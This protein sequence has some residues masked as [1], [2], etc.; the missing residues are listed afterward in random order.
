MVI[1]GHNHCKIFGVSLLLSNSKCI[2]TSCVK[3]GE[4][5]QW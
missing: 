4:W 3:L 1:D 2:K 5:G